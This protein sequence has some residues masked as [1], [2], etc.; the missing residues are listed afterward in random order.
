GNLLG[1]ITTGI[2]NDEVWWKSPTA[3][4]GITLTLSSMVIILSHYYGIK[5]RG[6]KHYLKTYVTPV[7]FIFPIKIVEE[8][9]NTLTLALRLFGNFSPGEVLLGLLVA[10]TTT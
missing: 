8:F 1:V 9:A 2:V 3:D 4:P 5:M 10:L 6:T 7:W